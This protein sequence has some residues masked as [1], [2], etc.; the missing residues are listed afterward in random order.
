MNIYTILEPEYVTKVLSEKMISFDFLDHRRTQCLDDFAS[1]ARP[2]ITYRSSDFL[3]MLD[4]RADELLGKDHYVDLN[5]ASQFGWYYEREHK[6]NEQIFAESESAKI[7]NLLRLNPN[8]RIASFDRLRPDFANR[9]KINMLTGALGLCY[10]VFRSDYETLFAKAKLIHNRLVWQTDQLD[11]KTDYVMILQMVFLYDQKLQASKANIFDD[12]PGLVAL[13]HF[14]IS[15]YDYLLSQSYSMDGFLEQVARNLENNPE[16]ET[17]ARSLRDLSEQYVKRGLPFASPNNLVAATKEFID[18][19]KT[20]TEKLA[21]FLLVKNSF[22]KT[23][24]F[25]LGM[26]HLGDRLEEQFRFGTFVPALVDLTCRFLVDTKIGTDTIELEF[27]ADIQPELTESKLRTIS[28]YLAEL[29][30][31]NELALELSQLRRRSLV[32]GDMV[33][34]GKS[35]ESISDELASL[36]QMRAELFAVKE[37]LKGNV[38]TL[39]RENNDLKN[40]LGAQHSTKIE[41][42]NNHAQANRE[43]D[44]LK[45]DLDQ[46]KEVQAGFDSPSGTVSAQPEKGGGSASQSPVPP[47]VRQNSSGKRKKKTANPKE[48]ENP[49]E[50][51]PKKE[52]QLPF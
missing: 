2:D 9:K 6:I 33:S 22:T 1:Y 7:K 11:P 31:T 50:S 17:I 44:R 19:A 29:R 20:D 28:E 46:L 3:V 36:K 34:T 40:Q 10:S 43:I 39:E 37:A 32:L 24:V 51:A 38:M 48:E 23:A 18:L 12:K 14:L 30:K 15:A 21:A 8:L 4:E 5:T 45:V 27:K 13:R 42:L 25:L 49:K 16:Y 26:L 52:E 47:T 35:I 41:L